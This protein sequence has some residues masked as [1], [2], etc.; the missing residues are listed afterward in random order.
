M[1]EAESGQRPGRVGKGVLGVLALVILALAGAAGFEL[2]VRTQLSPPRDE[3]QHVFL[4]KPLRRTVV[5]ISEDVPGLPQ[6]ETLFTTNSLGLRGDE[7]DLAQRDSFRIVTLGGS[8]SECMVLNDADAWPRRLQDELSRRTGKP[9]WVGNAARSGEAT[10]DYIA[11]AQV[12][13]PQFEP[14]LVVIM[15]GGND[16]QAMVEG[17]YFPMDLSQPAALAQYTARLYEGGD[18]DYLEPLYLYYLYERWLDTESYDLAPLYKTMKARRLAAPK[19]AEIEDFDE[20]LDIY[21]SNLRSLYAM[22]LRMRPPPRIVFMTHPFLWAEGMGKEEEK[23]LWAGYSCMQCPT[24]RFY[25]HEA[26]A[27]GLRQMNAELLSFCAE[28][29]L[30]C[31]DLEPKLPKTLDNFYDD[32]HLKEPGANRVAELLGEFLAPQVARR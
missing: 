13:L 12:L 26:L 20:A 3:R 17:R 10:L 19:V 4:R 22:L 31:F 23:A 9:V 16:L 28:R 21:R 29:G 14:D 6:R 30:E 11:H 25:A 8:V 32:G 1:S 27:R 5:R 15:P 7:L 18:T 2:L 24:Q